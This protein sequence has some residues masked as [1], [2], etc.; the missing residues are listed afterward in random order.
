MGKSHMTSR[1]VLSGGAERM[2]RVRGFHV[3]KK[4]NGK[5]FFPRGPCSENSVCPEND[6]RLSALTCVLLSAAF[7]SSC[8][9]INSLNRYD[10]D[11]VSG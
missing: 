8:D 4:K 7:K 1:N 10:S 9:R 2:C 5:F 3:F 6:A 11:Q